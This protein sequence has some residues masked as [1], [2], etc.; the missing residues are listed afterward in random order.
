MIYECEICKY[1]TDRSSNYNEH[2]KTKIHH[3]RVNRYIHNVNAREQTKL[4]KNQDINDNI[5]IRFDQLD[6]NLAE[7]Q[8]NTDKK[9]NKMQKDIT[10]IKSGVNKITN[11]IDFLNKYCSD[12]KPLKKLTDKEINKILGIDE[13]DEKSVRKFQET[14]IE[15]MRTDTTDEYISGLL[16]KYFKKKNLRE[17]VL[18][19]TDVTRL[20]FACVQHVNNDESDSEEEEDDEECE[21]VRDKKGILFKELVAGPIVQK[22]RL[23]M[24]KYAKI[25]FSKYN[26]NDDHMT[27]RYKMETAE[28]AVELNCTTNRNTL[29]QKISKMT[30]ANLSLGEE[31][32]ELIQEMVEG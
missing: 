9:F 14:I 32:K 12:A 24:N 27:A 19:T 26:T 10:K 25:I 2:I 22:I 8:K 28:L 7:N 20:N 1:V 30:S 31:K 15:T 13:K 3:K 21:W 16:T 5:N 6:E 18:W 29:I 4:K 17:Q 11:A 23:L